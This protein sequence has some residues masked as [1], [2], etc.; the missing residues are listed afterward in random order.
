[1]VIN[2]SNYLGLRSIDQLINYTYNVSPDEIMKAGFSTTDP[3]AG[4]NYNPLF[5]AMAW[6]NFNLE[7]NIFAAL[8]NMYGTFQVSVY[9]TQKPE[10]LLMQVQVITLPKVVLLKVD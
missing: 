7:A 5:G 10:H 8:P 6:A 1:V 3:G 4:G 2:M 9:T